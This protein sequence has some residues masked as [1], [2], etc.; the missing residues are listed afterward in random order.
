MKLAAPNRPSLHILLIILLSLIAYSNT[1][2]SSF[3]FDDASVIVENPIIKDLRY[4][5]QPSSAR[6]FRDTFEYHTFKQRYIGYLTFALNYRLHGLNVT[7]YH[8]VNIFIHICASL[9]LYFFIMLTFKT[10]AL[11]NSAIRNYAGHIALFTALLFA[12]HPLQTQAV[13]YIW[14]RV[15]SLSTMLYLL[16]LVAYIK[17]R[18]LSQSE[19]SIEHGV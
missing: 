10:P 8:F 2:N 11:H 13:T 15:T 4:F 9:L 14:Q 17:W 18:L 19:K 16:S 7:G 6:D 1:F 5:A 12:C 3:H